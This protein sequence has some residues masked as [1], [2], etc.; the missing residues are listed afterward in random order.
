MKNTIIV[1]EGADKTGKTT[2]I[3]RFNKQTNFKYLVLDRFTISSKV[4]NEYFSR[5]REEYYKNIENIFCNSFN[6]L[7]IY[8]YC[9]ESDNKKRLID[10][11]EVLPINIKDYK[12]VNA[13]FLENIFNSNYKKYLLVDTT[14]HNVKD[15]VSKIISF[16]EDNDE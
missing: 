6:V 11:G 9:S 8:C 16:V 2:L 15:C 1:F 7:L 12:D 10:N 3:N 4:Y 13:K 14:L 5:N